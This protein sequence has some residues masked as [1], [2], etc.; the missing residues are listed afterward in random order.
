[1]LKGKQ[2]PMY[3]KSDNITRT[4]LLQE[5]F[6]FNKLMSKYGIFTEENDSEYYF[7]IVKPSNGEKKKLLPLKNWICVIP[8]NSKLKAY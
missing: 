7:Q 1:M 8:P 5:I 2:I 4:Y 3:Y 6:F